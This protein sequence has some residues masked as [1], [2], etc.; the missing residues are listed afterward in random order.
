ML[1]L[2][3]LLATLALEPA[4]V[5]ASVPMVG[6]TVGPTVGPEGPAE[7]ASGEA[8]IW[9]ETQALV[10]AGE[11]D[12]AVER[13]EPLADAYPQDYATQLEA[14]Y[15]AFLA[16]DYA[17]AEARYAAAVSLSNGAATASAGLAWTHLRQGHDRQARDEFEDVLA[18]Q[19]GFPPAVEGLAE[20]RR[21]SFSINPI[22]FGIGHI[23]FQHPSLAR[24]GGV[25][26]GLP[27][28]LAR[29]LLVTGGYTYTRFTP[30]AAL[31]VTRAGPDSGQGGSGSGSGIWVGRANPRTTTDLGVQGFNQHLAHVG[32]GGTW[33]KVGFLAQYAYLQD[34]SVVDNDAHALGLSLRASPWG[35]LVLDTSAT[36][37]VRIGWIGRAALSWRVPATAW[38][39]VRPGVAGQ[40]VAGEVLPSGFA[41]VRF[42]GRVGALTLGGKGGLEERPVYLETP[43]IFAFAGRIPW[44]AWFAGEVELSPGV[45]LLAS[46]ETHALQATPGSTRFFA[47]A[48][49]FGAGLQWR[50]S[51]RRP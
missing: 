32:L 33:A 3:V 35:D 45:H 48:H 2:A 12:R 20:L 34:A 24:A 22:V 14:A 4:Q 8:A 25:S 28:L 26:V 1:S 41:S 10:D 31:P 5:P 16:G 27:M 19:P 11:L 17:R 23:Y 42:H 46:Y 44:G 47:Q 30:T 6:P 51:E 9:A 50:S 37:F 15:L 36:R 18:K 29:H 39:D 13:F 49:Y 38:L 21:R 43:A 7:A 40:L